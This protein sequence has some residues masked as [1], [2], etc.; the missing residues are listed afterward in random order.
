[1]ALKVPSLPDPI[2]GYAPLDA[3]GECDPAPKEGP[4]AVRELVLAELGG[5]DLG[6]GRDCNIGNPSKHHGGRAW[7]WGQPSVAAAEKLVSWLTATDPDGN[8]DA[9]ARRLGI[10]VIIWN[11]RIWTAGTKRF[12]PYRGASPH[13]DHVHVGWSH[14]GAA[15]TTSAYRHIASMRG[16]TSKAVP[17]AIALA[18]I[19]GALW[20]TRLKG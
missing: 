20:L 5:R 14:E 3:A 9:M 11:R 12:D 10:R 2:E 13:T 7:D 8:K 18:A 17:L 15:G 16:D 1:M 6:I 4:K 19:A